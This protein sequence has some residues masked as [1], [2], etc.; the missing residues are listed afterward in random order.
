MRGV[1]AGNMAEKTADTE[2]P[3]DEDRL[4][5]ETMMLPI[6]PDRP[7]RE[8]EAVRPPSS[9]HEGQDALHALKHR[10]G[11]PASRTCHKGSACKP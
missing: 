5:H 4:V 6:G 8:S 3:K 11:R 1:V 2:A 7:L 10:Y 9:R